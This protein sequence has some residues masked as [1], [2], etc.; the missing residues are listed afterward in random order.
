MVWKGGSVNVDPT[1]WLLR[2]AALLIGDPAK[3]HGE[4]QTKG[5]QAAARH[6]RERFNDWQNFDGELPWINPAVFSEVAEVR[7][8]AQGPFY[9]VPG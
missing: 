5:W 9:V 3:G 4:C 2:E 1:E 8:D 7:E 6:W